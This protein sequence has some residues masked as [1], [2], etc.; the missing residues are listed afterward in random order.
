MRRVPKMSEDFSPLSSEPI[1]VELHTLARVIAAL[2][3]EDNG[4]TL[5]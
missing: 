1:R 4:F 2:I 5:R 3:V